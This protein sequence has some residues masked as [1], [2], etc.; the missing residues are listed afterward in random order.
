M[1]TVR[2]MRR[3]P[4]YR[5][6]MASVFLSVTLAALIASA[7]VARAAA[8]RGNLDC[9]GYSPI[10]APL[11]Q[12]MMCTEVEQANS[13]NGYLDNGWYVGHDEPTVEFISNTPGSGNS[14][15]YQLTLPTEPSLAPSGSPSGPV[16]DFQLTPAFWF[17]MVLCDTQ[18]WPEG[19][20]SCTPDSNTNIQAPPQP[21]HAGTAYMELQ[22]YPPGWSPFISQLSCDQVH[23]CV[24]LNIDSFEANYDFS[25]VNT[26]CE[27]PVNFAF[28][29]HDGAPIGPP[30]P[31]TATAA[32]FDYPANSDVLLMNP[33]DQITVSMHDTS[34]G[35]ATQ[36]TD[37]TTH[38]TGTM[39][40]SAANGFRHIVWDPTGHT[41][42]GARYT[43]HPE[44]STSAGY[45][46]TT[47]VNTTP[48]EPST[49]LEPQTWAGWSAHTYNVAFAVETGHFEA[50]DT[51][52]GEKP[53]KGQGS[54]FKQEE[55][56]CFSGPTIPGCIGTD[57]P[58]FDGYPYQADWPNS[59]SAGAFP[60]PT[61]TSSPLSQ[62]GRGAFA[63]P[64]SGIQFE[65]DLPRIEAPDSGGTCDRYT[66]AGCSDPPP[67]AAFYPWYHEVAPTTGSCAFTLANT[68]P[69]EL[70]GYGG[71]AA[72]WGPL[73]YTEYNT[74]ANGTK[75]D[76][77]ASG[78]LTNPCP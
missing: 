15:Q 74:E 1:V 8:H 73:E 60:S 66:G 35:F 54:P 76:N 33:G 50:P 70:N 77:Y 23:W 22:F 67:G 26:N 6:G 41:C 14:A 52:S 10:Q 2:A 20:S 5:I 13:T 63:N 59:M 18:S 28:L 40:A 58:D 53:T 71:E 64:Y 51:G 29:T 39:V 78:V 16:W 7:G 65:A 3:Y 61:L 30:G 9:N 48:G 25:N 49:V 62:N 19:T 38:T 36:V 4:I 47:P 56:P 21:N 32:T 69:G 75:T 45:V 55:A 12:S 17:G 24:S 46:S 57:V 43:F 34:A 31:D 27:E 68:I 11:R 42:S 44:Y 37:N 72:A